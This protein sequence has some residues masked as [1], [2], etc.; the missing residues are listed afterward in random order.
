MPLKDRQAYYTALVEYLAFGREPNLKGAAKAV[1]TAIRP[2]LDNSRARAE[3][4]RAGGSKSPSRRESKQEANAQANAQANR[5]QTSKQKCDFAGS[6][7]DS[8]SPSYS[9]SGEG[10]QGEGTEPPTVEEVRAYFQANCLRGDPELF[11][12]T[13]DAKGWVDGS[14]FPIVS[15][16]SQAIRWSKRQV[17]IDAER[18]ARGEPAAEEA[19]WRPAQSEDP[20]KAARDADEAYREA[21]SKLT[22]EER[23]R[24]NLD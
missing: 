5:K 16:T 11:H 21:V 1:F 6:Y 24:F 12:A 9:P 7:Q 18:A 4:G 14:G 2:T 10:V 8:P 13:Y 20:E 15:W 17:G 22:P 3:A 23:E 19:T